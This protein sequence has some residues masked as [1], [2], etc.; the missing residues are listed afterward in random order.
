MQAL[1]DDWL[2]QQLSRPECAG[3]TL[4]AMKSNPAL[5]AAYKDM[6]KVRC[7]RTECNDDAVNNAGRGTH[8]SGFTPRMPCSVFEG[9]GMV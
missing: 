2:A 4:Q 1:L 6:M 8:S 7:C 3:L 5:V 9:G